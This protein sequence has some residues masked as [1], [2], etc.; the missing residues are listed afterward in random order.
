MEDVSGA[1][2]GFCSPLRHG[3]GAGSPGQDHVAIW[4]D[5]H[6]NDSFPGLPTGGGRDPAWSG[7]GDT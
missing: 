3:P 2:P 4:K 1:S 7:A 5:K 6:G